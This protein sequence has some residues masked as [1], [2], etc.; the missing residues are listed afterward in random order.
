[1]GH[2]PSLIDQNILPHPVRMARGTRSAGTPA[3]EEAPLRVSASPA[4]VG[5]FPT[6]APPP[7][8]CKNITHDGVRP[9]DSRTFIYSKC[10]KFSSQKTAS[11][12]ILPRSC[13]R[14]CTRAR[15]RPG[16]ASVQDA[17]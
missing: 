1:M 6:V 15:R 17:P 8:I 5:V 14:R 7:A 16:S 3:S 11:A 2:D 13:G 9:F 10:H 12:A 4:P